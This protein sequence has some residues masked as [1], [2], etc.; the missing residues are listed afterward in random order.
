MVYL[1][2][3]NDGE[4]QGTE[5]LGSRKPLLEITDT[6]GTEIR[7]R[8]PTG[9]NE[10]DLGELRNPAAVEIYSAG[11]NQV[12]GEDDGDDNDDDGD[13]D[14]SGELDADDIASWQGLGE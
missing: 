8:S 2:E 6:W 9:R 1:D 4:R 11:A 7:Y 10:H 5:D 12:F 3:D 14:E 13:T